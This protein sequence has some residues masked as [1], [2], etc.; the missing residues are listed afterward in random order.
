MT[1]ANATDGELLAAFVR[2]KSEASFEALVS[3]HGTMVY[4]V[5][6]RALG[7]H[8][9][10]DA[11]Q[12]V[13]LTLAHKA[14]SLQNRESIAGWLHHVAWHVS[15]RARRS[16]HS[17]KAREQGAGSMMTSSS[18][19]EPQWEQ[20]KELLDEE[21]DALPEKYRQPLLLHYLEGQTQEAAAKS[22]GWQPGTVATRLHRGRELLKERLARRGA[23][24]SLALLATLISKNASA[25]ALPS[26]FSAA[27]A[28]A[29][30]LALAGQAAATVGVSTQAIS[31]SKGVL[32][33][34]FISQVKLA[35]IVTLAA[36]LLVSGAVVANRQIQA[37]ADTAPAPSEPKGDQE[38]SPP[39][40]SLFDAEK[41][42]KAKAVWRVELAEAIQPDPGAKGGRHRWDVV[43][44]LKVLQ[45]SVPSPGKTMVG[46][47]MDKAGVPAGVSTIY[48]VHYNDIESDPQNWQLVGDSAETGVSHVEKASPAATVSWKDWLQS[49]A[50]GK[51]DAKEF[52]IT[53]TDTAW[54]RSES[55]VVADGKLTFTDIH[56]EM[57]TKTTDYPLTEAGVRKLARLAQASEF[58]Q[59]T[60]QPNPPKR[61][62]IPADP[63]GSV[64]RIV[65]EK[66]GDKLVSTSLAG[67]NAK[68][69]LPETCALIDAIVNLK[70]N[71]E[72][73]SRANQT[74]KDWLQSIADGKTEAKDLKLTVS[75]VS[76]A[77]RVTYKIDGGSAT[78]DQEIFIAPKHTDT[79]KIDNA[80]DLIKTVAKLAAASKMMKDHD[81]HKNLKQGTFTP[82]AIGM[83]PPGF[84]IRM[85]GSDEAGGKI[86]PPGTPDDQRDNFKGYKAIVAVR[87]W[88]EE[89]K[90][91][92]SLVIEAGPGDPLLGTLSYA[93]DSGDNRS[94]GFDTGY[95][96]KDL[97]WKEV[98]L[99][100]G[101]KVNVEVATVRDNST[102]RLE[103]FPKSTNFIAREKYAE[104]RLQPPGAASYKIVIERTG[105]TFESNTY[106]WFELLK[107]D[108]DVAELIKTLNDL[109]TKK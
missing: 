99:S 88:V 38:A 92:Q 62:D 75:G 58:I 87:V 25:A 29:A 8:D 39:A 12:A 89:L 97:R 1:E 82:A 34:M 102:G 3:R 78:L 85:A 79:T 35:A 67:K 57:E 103:E 10:E 50:D 69:S 53:V 46:H 41:A 86:P 64:T 33:A 72:A 44:V 108:P 81:A 59:D 66:P 27:T 63:G 5:C 68:T 106:G 52:K 65:Y 20:L 11:A 15:V 37:R 94:A 48:V 100:D 13:F 49:I 105:E 14:A 107:N 31:L 40:P 74:W 93:V 30:T 19:A 36:T 76:S 32:H 17:Q 2:D 51:T 80:T 91:W 4:N 98:V 22:L 90:N 9:A 71:A 28:K 16:T 95:T 56:K 104:P 83:S 109:A 60:A 43:K 70:K 45:G 47:M 96:L 84:N 73:A 7:E 6:R 61:T 77:M 54:N 21:L 23:V 42:K 26:A 18:T 24:L 101:R 55:Y